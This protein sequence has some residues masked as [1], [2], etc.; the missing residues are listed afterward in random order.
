MNIAVILNEVKD[1]EIDT[2]EWITSYSLDSSAAASEWQKKNIS[3]L[4]IFR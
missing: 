4:I 3:P 1:P 2:Q